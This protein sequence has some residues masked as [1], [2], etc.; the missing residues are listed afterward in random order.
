MRYDR[1]KHVS[2]NQFES[3]LRFSQISIRIRIRIQF[4]VIVYYEVILWWFY[5]F[6]KWYYEFIMMFYM[7]RN[8]Q[9]IQFCF[10]TFFQDQD[11]TSKINNKSYALWFKDTHKIWCRSAKF[12]SKS[13]SCS[14]WGSGSGSWFYFGFQ[15]QTYISYIEDTD[16]ILFGS[17]NS[18]ESYCVHMKSPRACG[19]TDRQTDIFLH[20]LSSKT[21][22]KWTLVKMREFFF[23]LMRLQY[24][25]FLHT[26]YVM[27]K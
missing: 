23:S 16:Q 4:L 10:T 19:Q 21:Y 17:A 14:R 1:F 5:D 24:F 27:R 22:K 3:V 13:K 25:L 26:P 9:E 11:S 12:F 15:Y 2:I 20:V 6:M 18:F 8:G 7:S